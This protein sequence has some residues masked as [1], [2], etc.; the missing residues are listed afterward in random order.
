MP[1]SCIPQGFEEH[2]SAFL[3]SA[4]HLIFLDYFTYEIVNKW[5]RSW[6]LKV[7]HFPAISW[8][9]ELRHSTSCS[10][11]YNLLF[12]R[13]RIHISD[14]I[15]LIQ[16]IYSWVSSVLLSDVRTVHQWGHDCYPQHLFH[17]AYSLI[18]DRFDTVV[19]A[20]DSIVKWSINK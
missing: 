13:S 3:L 19:W 5:W 8:L 15:P 2:L 7:Q 18:I 6:L 16:Q 17:F 9:W 12:C 10:S 11:R 14:Q 4:A 1:N 20:T